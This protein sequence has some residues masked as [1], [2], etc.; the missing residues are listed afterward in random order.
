MRLFRKTK[1]QKLPAH[2]PSRRILFVSHEASRTGA[3][4]IILNILKHFR[5]RCDICCETIL[6]AGGPLT[7]DFYD[8]SHLLDCLNHPCAPSARLP[9]KLKRLVKRDGKNLPALAI[10]NSMESRF[11]ADELAKLGVPV[12]SLLHELPSSYS[13]EDYHTVFNASRKVVFPVD[14]V[15]KAA[16]EVI[17]MPVDKAMVMSQGLL[18]SQFGQRVDRE[19]AR[20]S[21]CD[22]L[23]I[24][25]DSFLVLG[26]GTLDLRKGIDHFAAVARRVAELNHQSETPIHFV[27]VGG[28]ATYRHSVYHYIQLDLQKTGANQFVHFVGEQD[29]PESF[30]VASDAFFMSSRVDPFPCVIHEAMASQLP[31]VTFADSGGAQ[32]AIKDGAGFVVPYADYEQAAKVFCM[33]SD[34]AHVAASART[35]SFDRVHSEYRFEDYGDELVELAESII[36][37]SICHTSDNSIG[38]PKLRVAA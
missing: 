23:G 21:I 12:I 36:G 13:P 24:P 18:D 30:F 14:D 7:T 2:A 1:V 15:Y 27:W 26:C 9:R 20:K 33:L 17:R 6:H 4:K 11:A 22:Q 35:R 34:H 37:Q 31:I 28:G 19:T 38:T 16:A 25:S 10:C 5:D 3:P 8:H 32:T 29:N